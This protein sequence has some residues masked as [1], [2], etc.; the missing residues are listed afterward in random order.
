VEPNGSVRGAI[1]GAISGAHEERPVVGAGGLGSS[2]VHSECLKKWPQRVRW[3]DRAPSA[4]ADLNR[5]GA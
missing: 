2:R 4:G 3:A 1:R 5:K